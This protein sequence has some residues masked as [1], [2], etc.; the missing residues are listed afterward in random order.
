[1]S[2]YHPRTVYRRKPRR[3][4]GMGSAFD[5]EVRPLGQSEARALL[6]TRAGQRALSLIQI[7]QRDRAERELRILQTR[8]GPELADALFAI[9]QAAEMPALALRLGVVVKLRAG[10]PHDAATYPLPAWRPK[11]GIIVDRAL[12]SELRR[13]DTTFHPEPASKA[14]PM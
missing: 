3:S 5:W 4:L 13:T 9:S 8:A 12:L 11:A 10:K 7:G 6:G 14:E 2:K 1:M